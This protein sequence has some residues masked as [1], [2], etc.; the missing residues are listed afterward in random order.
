MLVVDVIVD[1]AQVFAIIQRVGVFKRGV[2]GDRRVAEHGGL[3]NHGLVDVH[4][5][6][7]ISSDHGRRDGV[8]WKRVLGARVVDDTSSEIAGHLVCRGKRSARGRR[9]LAYFLPVLPDE[10]E[11]LVLF[12]RATDVVAPIVVSQFGEVGG[13]EIACVQGVVAQVLEGA[14][15]ELVGAVL[16]PD[17]EGRAGR[18]SVLGGEVRSLD[19]DFL[20]EIR[21]DVIDQATIGAVV[22]VANSIH[23]EAVLVRAMAVDRLARGTEAGQGAELVGVGYH[24]ARNQRQEFGVG[25]PVQGEVLHLFLIDHVGD[26][27]RGGVEHLGAGRD[28]FH[29]LPH[30]AHLQ[31]EIHREAAIGRDVDAGLFLGLESRLSDFDG[32]RADGQLGRHVVAVGIRGDD[33][34]ILR[35]GIPYRDF[36]TGNGGAGLVAH[37]SGNPAESGLCGDRQHGEAK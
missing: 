8:V 29:A 2:V 13:E 3:R 26:F 27:A 20:Q 17:I 36:D 22:Q 37:G 1:A 34:N 9:L 35:A 16:G 5:G 12:D 4:D 6:S 11:H 30:V 19:F 31:V 10:E 32:V 21:A 18:A 15:V 14:A 33:A 7:T 28:Y 24:G 23:R 25:T